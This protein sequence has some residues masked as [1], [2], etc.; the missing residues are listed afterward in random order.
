L[1]VRLELAGTATESIHIRIS[2]TELIVAG[3]RRDPL[4]PG[5]RRIDRMEIPFGPFERII[6]LPAPVV[7]DESRAHLADGFLEIEL[8]LAEVPM[9]RAL[10]FELRI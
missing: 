4:R 5:L 9:P 2:D 7:V 1:I 6:P 10:V 8:P 3:T